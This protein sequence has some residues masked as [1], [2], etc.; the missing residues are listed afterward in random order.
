M[1]NTKSAKKSLKQDQRRKQ[2]NLA[3][4]RKLK[5]LLKRIQN[6]SSQGKKDEAK[7]LLP[8]YDKAVDKAAKTNVIKQNT[9]SRKKSSIRRLIG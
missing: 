1:P 5:D 3:K 7:Q 9:A 4:K 6:L 8:N 2:E